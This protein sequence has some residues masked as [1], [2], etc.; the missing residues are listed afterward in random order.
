M[1]QITVTEKYNAVQEGAMAKKEFVR[2]MKLAYPMYVSN[3]DDFNSTIQILKTRNLLYEA[4]KKK[5]IKKTEPKST[6]SSVSLDALDRGVRIELQSVGHDVTLGLNRITKEDYNKAYQKALTN[7]NANATHYLDLMSGESNKVDKHDK[8]VEVKRGEGAIDVFNGLKKA[9]LKEEIEGNQDGDD[10]ELSPEELANKHAGS[11]MKE[12]EEEDAKNDLDSYD[13]DF[14]HQDES[15]T[16]DA[17][18][19][20]LGKVVGALRTKYPDI[21]GGVLKD[22]ILTHGQDLLNGADIEDEFGEYISVNYEGPSDMSEAEEGIDMSSKDGYIS[23][24]DNENILTKYTPE[25][26]EEMA[27]ELAM[28]H[29]DAGQDQDN[30]VR[31]F[32]AAYKEGGHDTHD[33]VHE[34]Q[35]KDHDGDGDIDGDD[36]MAS[37]DKAIKKAMG[38]DEGY[39]MKRMQ[40]AHQQA[41]QAGEKSAYDKKDK[42]KKDKEKQLKEAIK[43][44]I[45]TTLN[46][47]VINEAATARLS[48]WGEG[49]ETFEGVKSVVHDLENVVTEV[50]TFFDKVGDKIAKIFER[51]S[52]FKNDEGLNIGAYIAPSLE[53]AF[54]QDLRPV[55]KKGFLTKISLPKVRTITQ[56]DVDANNL[57][58]RSTEDVPV[59]ET[60]FTP[61]F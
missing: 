15:M 59:K 29:H 27:R 54:K 17:K 2:Q 23:F 20:L 14:P 48:D 51:T 30:F 13:H 26:A 31:S 61:N 45:K 49:Y 9:T 3:F 32:M 37:K 11:P 38:K 8:A 43:S 4:A 1:R 58:E 6:P 53:V 41:S 50:E 40:Q 47:D 60:L 44:I 36:Y 10:E 33:Q 7:I 22:F 12:D 5:T 42:E 56:A 57:G 52:Q 35:G 24:I 25:D 55:S 46:E 16:E 28:T 39:A 18:K 34:K 19:Q 21:T